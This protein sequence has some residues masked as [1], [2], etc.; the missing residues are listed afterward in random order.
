M[1]EEKK[2]NTK[3]KNIIFIVFLLLF[4]F[5][6]GGGIFFRRDIEIQLQLYPCF[7]RKTDYSQEGGIPPNAVMKACYLEVAKTMQ[8][9]S[10]CYKIPDKYEYEQV[11]CHDS[12]YMDIGISTRDPSICEKIQTQ[13]IKDSCY[14][15]VE[16]PPPNY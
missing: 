11:T 9:P 8:D 16:N 15:L 12:Y 14:I 7:K 2:N 5:S 10:I 1:L 6:I 3:L 13:G 4:V